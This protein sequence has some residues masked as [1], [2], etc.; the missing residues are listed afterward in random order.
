MKRLINYMIQ[1][2]LYETALLI[3][4]YTKYVLYLYIDPEINHIIKIPFI[5]K[6]IE[7]IDLP[8]IFRDNAVVSSIPSNL[9]NTESLI[10]F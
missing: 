2:D 3:R 4:C 10:R 8:G 1:N 6:G 5:N 9:H 7:Y